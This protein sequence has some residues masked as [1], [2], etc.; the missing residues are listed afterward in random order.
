M[1]L[2]NTNTRVLEEH[3]GSK[4]PKYAILSHRWGDQELSLQDFQSTVVRASRA[5]YAKID[6]AC[7]Q[8]LE[9]DIN[10]LWVDTCC[11][12]KTS[13]AELT[14]SINS[15]FRWYADASV[16]FAYLADIEATPGDAVLAGIK[17]S[18][19]FSRGWTLQEL[20]APQRVEFFDKHWVRI[21]TRDD[22]ADEISEA[23][24]IS[25]RYL[26]DTPREISRQDFI[27]GA[28]IAERMSWAASRTTTRKEDQAYCLL[29]LFGVNMPL[30]YGEGEHAF[31]RLQEVILSRRQDPTLLAWNF[32]AERDLPVHNGHELQHVSKITTAWK[33]LLGRL[34]P[35]YF[36]KYHPRRESSGGILSLSP[37]NFESCSALLPNRSLKLEWRIIPQ[38]LQLTLPL[39]GSKDDTGLMYAVIPCHSP[40]YPTSLL[41]IPV[42]L[43]GDGSFHRVQAESIWVHYSKW[44]HWHHTTIT[45]S[46][47]PEKSIIE[48][49]PEGRHVHEE[50]W[51]RSLPLGFTLQAPLVGK[52]HLQHRPFYRLIPRNGRPIECKEFHSALILSPD[53]VGLVISLCYE[54]M[55]TDKYHLILRDPNPSSIT[56]ENTSESVQKWQSDVAVVSGCLVSAHLSEKNLLGANLYVVDVHYGMGSLSHIGAALRLERNQG[57]R[58]I[59]WRRLRDL[60]KHLWTAVPWLG[61]HHLN[62]SPES[63]YV[64]FFSGVIMFV[65]WL[66]LSTD[67]ASD[68][69]CYLPPWDYIAHPFPNDVRLVVWLIVIMMIHS[70]GHRAVLFVLVTKILLTDPRLDVIEDDPSSK[71]YKALQAKVELNVLLNLSFCILVAYSISSLLPLVSILVARSTVHLQRH[72]ILVCFCIAIC[73]I[74]D[75]ERY[76]LL[77]DY[78]WYL[79][80]APLTSFL[81]TL[82]WADYKTSGLE[83]Y[84]LHIFVLVSVQLC[85]EYMGANFLLSR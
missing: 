1:R 44:Y 37:Q 83:V 11:I 74:R 27:A 3:N 16:C 33:F 45:L 8:S 9:Q 84:T 62:P 77:R 50:V 80:V 56:T 30:I 63:C 38:G 13:S 24:S 70:R 36:R 20:L 19:W 72:R 55:N 23:T 58:S 51:V 54:T 14:E 10:Y 34:H 40:Q 25:Q 73:F 6:A 79:C 18:D 35:W 85:F 82:D 76:R 26:L 46:I 29:G 31:I 42:S 69:K 81:Y 12:D 2:I 17:G 75:H 41:A 5:G 66:D 7:D 32:R 61:Y 65:I 48:N 39:S 64:T 15:M 43:M 53:K 4:I 57:G 60:F 78:T 28:T 52:S 21:S 22:M 49:P 71:L 68:K 59:H 47:H 67:I